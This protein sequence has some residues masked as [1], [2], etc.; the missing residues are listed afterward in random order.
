LNND[1]WENT[2]LLGITMATLIYSKYHAAIL[3]ILVI[4]SNLNLLKNLRFYLATILAV[5][6]FIPH[7]YWQFIND[8][9]SF[10]YH[11][12][13]RVAGLDFGN[14]P[15]YLGNTLVFHNPVI[16]PLSIWLFTR[17]RPA[18]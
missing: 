9:P 7:I 1:S 16:L 5:L 11:L 14:I 17:C 6:L 2:I 13:D 3:I 12:V 4:L 15:E 18:N 10:R 8:F